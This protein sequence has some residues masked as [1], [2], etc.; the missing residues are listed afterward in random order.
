MQQDF[1]H[2]RIYIQGNVSDFFQRD[3]YYSVCILNGQVQVRLNASKGELVLQ[4][5]NTFNDGKYHS[6]TIIKKRKEIELRIDD[7]YQTAGKLPSGI[8]IK[9]PD[10]N[11]GL[12][13]GGLPALINNTKMVATNTPL[14]GAIRDAIFN[15]E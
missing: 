13:F 10:S 12:F 5:N 6:V 7:A 4:S 9:A 3:G 8:A 14:Y 2:Y 11:G 15:D 1:V